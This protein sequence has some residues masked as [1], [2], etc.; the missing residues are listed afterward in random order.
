VKRKERVPEPN[1]YDVNDAI[2]TL[3]NHAQY[4]I[5]DYE[6]L[7]V[8]QAVA[9]VRY[10]DFLEDQLGSLVEQFQGVP[11]EYFNMVRRE[12]LEWRPLGPTP[13]Y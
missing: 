11:T 13:L 9:L 3:R 4:G 8:D 6:R 7:H 12:R 1:A 10:I 2:T 5:G